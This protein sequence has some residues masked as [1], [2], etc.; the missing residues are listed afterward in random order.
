MIDK[1]AL[2]EQE[3]AKLE[4][5]AKLLIGDARSIV[6]EMHAVLDALEQLDEHSAKYNE[7]NTRLSELSCRLSE[8]NLGIVDHALPPARCADRPWAPRPG[9]INSGG[10][11]VLPLAHAQR[12]GVRQRAQLLHHPRLVLAVRN[13][14]KAHL[15]ERPMPPGLA[16]RARLDVDHAVGLPAEFSP[17]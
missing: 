2:S 16:R 11:G 5:E 3:T 13:V 9:G 14:A 4:A 10:F 15:R 1:P 8:L 6:A 17:E 12:L 7:L